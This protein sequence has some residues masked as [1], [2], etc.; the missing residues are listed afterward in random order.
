MR[1]RYEV[2]WNILKCIFVEFSVKFEIGE[3]A[4]RKIAAASKKIDHN[5]FY[6]FFFAVKVISSFDM[7]MYFSAL[8]LQISRHL[9]LN[10]FKIPC[11]QAP[12]QVHK[13]ID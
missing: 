12:E 10:I 13:H 6:I 7:I 2:Y 3:G 1:F 11:H 9:H 8:C 4:G 5:L